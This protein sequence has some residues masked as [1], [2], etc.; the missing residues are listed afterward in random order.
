MR[1]VTRQKPVQ[2]HYGTNETNTETARQYFQVTVNVLEARKLSWTNPH[3]ANSYV[4]VV[5]GK[6]KQ[7]TGV[8][9]HML[10]PFYKE[11]F[12]FELY[13]SIKNVQEQSIWLAVMEPRCCAPPRMVG[14]AN[15]DLGTVWKQPHHQVFHKWAQLSVPRDPA[16]GVVG[17]LK[18]DISIVFRGDVRMMPVMNEDN[19]EE[20]LL[21][22][23]GSE[24]QRANYMITIHGA[25]GMPRGAGEK[26]GKLPS[27]FARVTFCGLMAK[28]A[29]QPRT[30]NPMYNEQ[31]SMVE[32]FPNMTHLINIDVCSGDGMSRVLGSTR[33]SLEEISHDGENGFLPTF[34]PS[35]L[36]MY[37]PG[38]QGGDPG[39]CYKGSLLVTLKTEVP[40]YQQ[41]IRSTSV[42][43]VAPI[44]ND[45]LW[46]WEDFCIFCPILEVSMLDRAIVGKLCGVAI[47]I[48]QI[49]SD[50]IEDEEF[51]SMVHEISSRKLHYTGSIDVLKCRPAYGYLD[52][53]NSYPVLQQAT[54]LPDL[55]FR[56]FRNNMVHGIVTDLE[57]ALEDIERRLKNSDY[58]TPN[59]LI[60]ALN[61]AL[62]DAADNIV[63][64]LDIIQDH[65]HASSSYD[66][67]RTCTELDQK[68]MALQKEEMEKVYRQITCRNICEFTDNDDNLNT[69]KYKRICS[70]SPRKRVKV[71]LSRTK[72]LAQD[73]KRFIFKVSDGSADIV[74][75]L[76]NGGSRVAYT[77]IPASDIIF[78][79]IPKQRGRFCGRL[80][81]IYMKPLKCPKHSNSLNTSCFCS[82]GKIELLLWMGLYKQISAFETYV[83]T[84]Y[85]IKVKEN[86][87]C[88]K[89]TTVMLECRLFVYQAKLSSCVDN[90]FTHT[91]VRISV[92]NAV[93]ETK[94]MQK[95]LAPVWNQLLKIYR[96]MFTSPE[97]M[98]S[99]PTVATV[100]VYD[101]DDSGN[102]DFIGRCDIQ[103]VVDDRHD[104]EHAPKLQWLDIHRGSEC[105]GQLLISAQLLQV[106]ETLMK[107]TTYGPVEETYYMSGTKDIITQDS[108]HLEPIPNN[109][110]PHS[111]TYKV[112]VYWWGLRDV[113]VTRKPCVVLQIDELTI[114]SDIIINKKSNVNFP[115]GRTSLKFEAILSDS[116]RPP[117]TIKLCDHST[118]GRTLFLGTNVV[119]NP[120]KYLVKWLPESQRDSSLRSI[121]ITSSNFFPITPILYLKTNKTSVKVSNQSLNSIKKNSFKNVSNWRRIF[122]SKEPDEEERALL[123]IFTKDREKTKPVD[124]VAKNG[125]DKDWW[126]R[127]YCS[128]KNYDVNDCE[129]TSGAITIY[130]IEL[131]AQPEFSKFKDWC[132]TLKL[133]NGKKTG[134]PEKDEQ[135]RCGYLKAGIVIYKWPP[136]SKTIAV[137]PQGVDLAKGYFNEYPANDSTRH[138]VRVYVIKAINLI[139]K[140]FTGKSDPYVVI[141]CGDKHLGDRDTYVHNSINPVFGKMYEFRCTLPEDYLLTVSLYDHDTIA[142][143]ELI[144][145][146]TIDLED[147]IYSKHRARVGIPKEYNISGSGK[148]RDCMK[149]SAIL[150]EL[151]LKNHI[152]PPV[153][154]DANTVILNGVEYKDYERAKSYRSPSECR[155]N[156]CLSLLH[157]WHAVPVCGYH[158]VPEHVE[159]R[160]LFNPERSAVEQG[161]IQL[162]VDIYP[163][164]A[165]YIPPPVDVT[166]QKAED[167]ELR[168]VVWNLKGLKV[169]ECCG[170]GFAN[171]YVK[172]WIGNVE[173]VQYTDVHY[174]SE[175]GEA[176]FN[177]RMI[178]NFQYQYNEITFTR[179]EAAFSEYEE[180][181]PPM[182]IVQVLD[183]EATSKEDFIEMSGKLN[184]FASRSIRSWWPVTFT[185]RDNGMKIA[186][187]MIELE[188]TLLPADKAM[189]IPVGIGRDPPSPLPEPWRYNDSSCGEQSILTL[190][191]MFRHGSIEYLIIGA[192]IIISLLGIVWY[193]EMPRQ[194]YAFIFE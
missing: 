90:M 126:M 160:S 22:P 155:Q 40:Y 140:E 67:N 97:R 192:I 164:N 57:V 169:K 122:C 106:P 30:C 125:E 116:Y 182:L 156:I 108:E 153:Y 73:L 92:M 147:R 89:A 8:R 150:E 138:M 183:N 189:L 181:V 141:G 186:V 15:I 60:I 53:T 38:N 86:E 177:W 176:A 161:K 79:D 174:R 132:S 120:Y 70:L 135:L 151:C 71:L 54:R 187:G 85:K 48:G 88:L 1:N 173:Q 118:F 101:T 80:Q 112:D 51:L 167:Y 121:S 9:K 69:F 7:R 185:D 137:S 178:F 179:S 47:T 124:A 149:P 72:S 62:D 170:K 99:N 44:K 18:V 13:E 87:M 27:T 55:R 36:Q 131:E 45:C 2:L 33:L 49:A 6:K 32:M 41:A 5:I 39:A 157:K 81:T 180:R 68:Q 56:M 34:G 104:Y 82:A 31:I 83:P 84:G 19:M 28:T 12:L 168:V 75:W 42:E 134:I 50:D 76:L 165:T 94:L 63:K 194:F 20:N 130:N 171:I 78:S 148:W 93:K 114:K 43:P 133:Y 175:F 100:E 91:F 128:Q 37:G 96:M 74:V 21:L 163:L 136:A 158:L 109:L 123:P 17:F 188:L 66:L 23:S 129:G 77:K 139:A 172:A 127:Y 117:L 95:S 193:F 166:P 119:K 111:S 184:L 152:P 61:K 146:T 46:T 191:S 29:V 59:D 3:S 11:Y 52:F 25:F 24:Q 143:D 113:N 107:S 64:Y 144:G 10:E 103:P 102:V 14:E 16:A 105:T 145:S 159:T 154:S 4:I 142:P 26:H 65:I 190:E 115:N 98:A 35:L 110:V 58:S 162:W